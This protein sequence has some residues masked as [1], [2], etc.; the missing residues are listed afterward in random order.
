MKSVTKTLA[1]Y[2]DVSRFSTLICV[3][4]INFLDFAIEQR[5]KQRMD[6]YLPILDTYSQNIFT[7]FERIFYFFYKG[8][9]NHMETGSKSDIK[10]AEAALNILNYLGYASQ[11]TIAKK[12]LQ[13]Y[14]KKN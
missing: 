2:H 4:L 10:D 3:T 8:I 12:F 13:T 5:D 1:L 11:Y 14:L 9:R 6:T 7:T